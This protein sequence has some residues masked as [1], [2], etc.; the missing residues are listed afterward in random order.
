VLAEGAKLVTLRDPAN[1][2]LE[3]SSSINARS[4]ALDYSIRR[5]LKAAESGKRADILEATAS[6][7]RAGARRLL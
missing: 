1:L 6:R 5:L 4:G 7:A 2:L 3:V